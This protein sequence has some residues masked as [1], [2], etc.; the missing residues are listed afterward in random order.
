[1]TH[2]PR[3]TR[4]ERLGRRAFDRAIAAGLGALDAT[5]L[6]IDVEFG[7]ANQ[8]NAVKQ[9]VDQMIELGA[10]HPTIRLQYRAFALRLERGVPVAVAARA[11]HDQWQA[12]RAAGIRELRYRALAILCR[13]LR[14]RR[15]SAF[16]FESLVEAVRTGARPIPITEHGRAS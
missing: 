16:A 7:P 9:L 6:R 2:N 8:I 3:D 15:I 1:M 12:N 13:L 11:F 4:L 10:T 14:R 5:K